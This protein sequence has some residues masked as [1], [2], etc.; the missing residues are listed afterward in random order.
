MISLRVHSEHCKFAQKGIFGRPAHYKYRP[1][2]SHAQVIKSV[3]ENS[4]LWGNLILA[5]ND[6]LGKL[7]V[8]T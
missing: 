1:F 8:F 2:S 3:P 4:P 6:A 5:K 7:N